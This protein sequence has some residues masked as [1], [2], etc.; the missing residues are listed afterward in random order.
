MAVD[1]IAFVD[2][3]SA[4]ATVRLSLSIAPWAV[5][6]SGTDLQ[7]PPFRRAIVST[8]LTDG[9]IIPAA[10]YD[11]R[12]ITLHLQLDATSPVLAA[13]QLQLLNRELD[14]PYNILKWQPEP[15]LPP[16]FFKTFRSP[17]YAQAHDH[18]INLYDFTV[19][20]QA[21]PFAYGT[22]ENSSST[23]TVNSD[24]ANGTNGKFFDITGVKGDVETPLMMKFGGGIGSHQTVFAM[25]RGGTPS[26]MG[27]FLQAEAMTQ[28]TNT[29]TQ[30]NSG[31]YSGSG[32]NSSATTFGS[33]NDL[34]HVRLST[35]VFPASAAVDVRGQYRVMARINGTVA[36]DTFALQLVHGQRP[37]T[38]TEKDVTLASVS[39]NPR[40]V[41]LGIIQIPEGFDPVNNGPTN[42]PLPVAGVKLQL[43]A[44]RL[45]GSGN[46]IF[47]YL[48]FMPADDIFCLVNWGTTSVTTFMLDGYTRTVYALNGSNQVQDNGMCFY[49]GDIPRVAPNVTNRICLIND[50][51]PEPLVAD[52]VSG[53]CT[54][55]WFYWPR[56][57][58]VRPVAT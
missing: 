9:S 41:D 58:Y 30:A 27:Y 12:V 53:T 56:Y 13:T 43:F 23:V 22:Q 24:P 15:S 57:L 31:A 44:S 34:S 28:G 49:T 55:D 14:R 42:S 6:F 40:M 16:V 52:L 32:N 19:N 8:L 1:S 38:N 17:D 7:P 37:V 11:N 10:A 50:A 4:T 20:I 3:I 36:G 46:L 39:V 48:L 2:Q 51:T 45:S 18:G 21:E 33:N 47:D 5:L 26:A 25:R 29:S 54:L 35:A